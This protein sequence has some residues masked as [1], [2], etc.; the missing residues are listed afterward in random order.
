MP[1]YREFVTAMKF[2]LGSWWYQVA[3]WMGG[4][5]YVEELQCDRALNSVTVDSYI[6][7]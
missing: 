2:G 4:D 3:S 6:A 5:Q 1:V 7:F